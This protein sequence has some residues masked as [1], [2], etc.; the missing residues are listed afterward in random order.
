MRSAIVALRWPGTKGAKESGAAELKREADNLRKQQANHAATCVG[1]VKSR[2]ALLFDMPELTRSVHAGSRRQTDCLAAI[3]TSGRCP[4]SCR[5]Q[6]Q[7]NAAQTGRRM[8][9]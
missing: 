1:F 7:N 9:P 4:K 8:R 3:C 5:P 2:F 6:G